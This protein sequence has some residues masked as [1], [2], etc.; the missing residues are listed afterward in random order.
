VEFGR[1]KHSLKSAVDA[2]DETIGIHL[3]EVLSQ[4]DFRNGVMADRCRVWAL[5]IS[6]HCNWRARATTKGLV[7]LSTWLPE[8]LTWAVRAKAVELH[9]KDYEVVTEAIEAYLEKL[10]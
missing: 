3:R 5:S 10:K 9:K 1:T 6:W 2:G 4:L 8:E 7:R